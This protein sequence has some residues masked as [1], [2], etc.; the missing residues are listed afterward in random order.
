MGTSGQSVTL[1]NSIIG[2][3]ILAMPFCFQQCGV[4]LATILLIF[5]GLVSRLTCHFLL[6]SAIMSRR[7]NFE[8]LA[9]HVFGAPGKMAVEIG[10]IGYLLGTCIAYFVVVGDLGPQIIAKMLNINQSDVLRT[11]VMVIVS[12]V[13]VL[14]LGLLRN[15]DSL[16]NVSAAT[17][18][19]YLCLVIKVVAEAMSRILWDEMSNIDMEL[20]KPEGILQCVPI[21]SMAMFCQTQLFEIFES[22]PMMSLEK[23]NTVTKNAINICTSVYILVGLFGYIAFCSHPISGNILVSLSPTKAS[24]AIKMGFVMSLAFSFPLII[25]PCRASLYSLLFHTGQTSH[26]DMLNH[27]IPEARFRCITI[28]IITIALLISLMIPNIELVLGLVGSTIGVMVCVIFPTT[29]FIC[30]TLKNTNERILAQMILCFGII[31][32]VLG[33][34]ANLQAAETKLEHY[35]E[36]FTPAQPDVQKVII[37]ENAFKENPEQAVN[38]KPILSEDKDTKQHVEVINKEDSAVQ[39]PNPVA[40]VVESI[41]EKPK[42]FVEERV[43]EKVEAFDKVEKIEP[44]LEKPNGLGINAIEGAGDKEVETRMLYSQNINK[45]TANK[46]S[47]EQMQAVKSDELINAMVKNVNEAPEIK[48]K[49]NQQKIEA[50]KEEALLDVLKQHGNEQ[51]ELMQEILQ[52]IKNIEI[53]S[54]E[55]VD[56]KKAAVENIQKMAN[57]AIQNIGSITEKPSKNINT[58]KAD[59]KKAPEKYNSPVK[60][61][62]ILLKV[63]DEIRAEKIEK[64]VQAG[65]QVVSDPEKLSK[66]VINAP[67]LPK[68]EGNVNDFNNVKDNNGQKNNQVHPS[69]IDH[70][71]PIP[72]AMNNKKQPN[73]VNVLHKDIVDANF[74]PSQIKNVENAPGPNDEKNQNVETKKK[75]NNL[76]T[77]PKMEKNNLREKRNV[78]DCIEKVFTDVDRQI[79]EAMLKSK[80]GETANAVNTKQVQQLSVPDNAV[81]DAKFAL[82]EK[83]NNLEILESVN[84]VKPG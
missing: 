83:F 21:F 15:V 17:I 28:A 75:L 35:G 11:S 5:S 12:V 16:S 24:D 61:K 81:L 39:P 31:I 10:I 22:L 4:V 60:A 53:N 40:P 66:P 48:A 57:I 20:W 6:K 63:Q 56:A 9:F 55:E 71:I 68:A 77:A 41:E 59:P 8:F 65:K 25:F 30:V 47:R 67:A 37:V 79:C 69:K 18:G 27:P 62:E 19:F 34:Y 82:P 2:V 13:C 54:K 84:K 46:I 76:N 3:G 33:T 52:E 23:M 70:N 29:C 78:E 1:A 38:L 80:N 58:L 51:K 42:V 32:M 36:R 45:S 49:S 64:P 14:P 26:H 74:A 7:R 72:I 43:K 44:K 50:F 73:L